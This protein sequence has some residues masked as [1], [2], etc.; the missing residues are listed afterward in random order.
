MANFQPKEIDLSKI[1]GG[2]EYK[3]GQGVSAETINAV[4]EGLGF[5]KKYYAHIVEISLPT[6]YSIFYGGSFTFSFI[7]SD[8]QAPEYTK[9][10]YGTKEF[11]EYVVS[12]YGTSSFSARGYASIYLENVDYGKVEIISVGFDG[13]Y[14]SITL[15]NPSTNKIETIYLDWNTEEEGAMGSII[16]S[17]VIREI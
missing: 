10:K 13:Y 5:L 17:Y 11:V 12:R 16:T 14:Y 6:S 8:K 4:I 9:D 2:Q 1:N 7:S 3:N 15:Q